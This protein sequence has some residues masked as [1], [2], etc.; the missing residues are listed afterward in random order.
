MVYFI[1]LYRICLFIQLRILMN[2]SVFFF[3]IG[4]ALV[5][6]LIGGGL[7]LGVSE[8]IGLAFTIS[9]FLVGVVVNVLDEVL[10]DD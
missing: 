3:L 6:M 8:Q 9:G 2:T 10:E 4:L 7:Y 5:L 1:F